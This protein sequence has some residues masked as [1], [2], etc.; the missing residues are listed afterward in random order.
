M[1][2]SAQ[3]HALPPGKFSRYAFNRRTVPG[4]RWVCD[5]D[6]VPITYRKSNPGGPVCYK[7][8]T[9]CVDI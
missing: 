2:I 8:V 4:R 5:E 6:K 1:D 3:L 9:D 7:S